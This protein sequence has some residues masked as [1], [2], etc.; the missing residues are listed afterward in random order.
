MEQLAQKLSLDMSKV[1][2]GI[3]NTGNTVSSSIPILLAEIIG[4]TSVQKVLLSGF[5]VGLSW[6]S[7]LL[8]RN[9]NNLDD[10]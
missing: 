3:Q 10:N 7:C 2:L 8:T 9:N 4:N 5:G 6:A 1:P